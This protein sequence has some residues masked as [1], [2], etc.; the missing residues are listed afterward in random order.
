M[1]WSETVWGELADLKYGKS[2]R[3]YQ[4]STGPYRAYRTNRP[5]IAPETEVAIPTDELSVL[6]WFSKTSGDIP[7]KM[8]SAKAES[9]TLGARRDALL[10]KLVSG[11]IRVRYLTAVGS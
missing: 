10:P 4:A 5:E 6:Y 7:D 11:E 2:L 9:R 1:G 3:G 8:E